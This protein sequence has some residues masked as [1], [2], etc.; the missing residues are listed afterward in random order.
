MLQKYWEN[1]PKEPVEEAALGDYEVELTIDENDKVVSTRYGAKVTPPEGSDSRDTKLV[2]PPLAR[3]ESLEES[4]SEQKAPKA[5]SE[6]SIAAIENN[7]KESGMPTEQLAKRETESSTVLD[8]EAT[9][10]GSD[11]TTPAKKK[12]KKKK[13][14]AAIDEPL[15][16]TVN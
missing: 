11:S 3:S 9:A 4:S 5:K 12:K 1:Q 16:S 14:A 8:G 15:E 7:N 10:A 6:E 2:S 13:A